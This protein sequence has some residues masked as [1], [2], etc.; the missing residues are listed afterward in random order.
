MQFRASALLPLAL[1]SFAAAQ[2]IGTLTAESHPKL[3][4][5]ECTKSGGCVTK[6]NSVVLDGNWRWLHSTSGATNCYDGNSWNTS[7]CPDPKTCATNC[8]MDGAD[9]S[10]T[11]GITTS[12]NSLTIRFVTK[13]QYSTN[14][15]GRVYLMDEQDRGYK[16]FNLLNKEFTFDVDVSKL[17]CGLNG[18]LY[19]SE[20]DADGGASRFPS[21]KAGA[22]YGTGYCDAQCPHD[23]KFINGEANVEGWNPSDEDANAGAGKYGTCCPEM[24]IWEANS[25]STAYTPHPCSVDGQSR[26]EGL[27]CGDGADRYSS[28]CDKDGCD[29]NAYRMGNTQFYG[30]GADK[31]LNTNQKMTVVTQ[32]ITDNGTSSGKL[33]EIRRKYVQNG[34]IVEN[35]QSLYPEVPGDSITDEFCDKQKVHFGDNN[36]FKALGGNVAMGRQVESTVLVM[37][38]WD[39]YAARM[40]WLDSAYPLDKDPSEP[41]VSR[42]SCPRDSG[43]PADVEK[44]SPNAQVTFSN[45][46]FGELDSTYSGTGGSNPP[47]SSTA[48]TPRPSSTTT[49]TPRPSTTTT[50]TPVPTQTQQPPANCA[51]KWGQ[52]GGIGFSGPSCCVSG[53]SCQ[54]L[55]DYYSQCL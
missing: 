2:Q 38:I 18:A 34:V 32:F 51:G 11:Y 33:V 50:T 55:N 6:Q 5:Q 16:M 22:K 49:T 3:T 48:T 45:I 12:G 47:V 28:I 54:K 27:D 17:P 9:Y 36:A 20:M 30:P 53:S 14:V 24:D 15:G 23:I 31:T 52:C 37:S 43:Y 26:C 44:N 7:L 1:A 35:S 41:G 25:I 19:F 10:G 8:A 46:R 40:L 42:G 21:N 39:D 13:G 4:T 29:F